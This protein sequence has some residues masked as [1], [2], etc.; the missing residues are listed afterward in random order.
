MVSDPLIGQFQI[1]F[2]DPK[3]EIGCQKYRNRHLV[4]HALTALGIAARQLLRL[5]YELGPNTRRRKASE[6]QTLHSCLGR[7]DRDFQLLRNLG[8]HKIPGFSLESP[9]LEVADEIMMRRSEMDQCLS[10]MPNVGSKRDGAGFPA[11]R[12]I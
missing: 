6:P 12:P 1:P 5:H 8:N 4:V 9:I 11:E 3:Y 2:L 7:L 10:S